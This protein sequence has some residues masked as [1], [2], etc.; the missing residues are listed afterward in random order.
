[1]TRIIPDQSLDWAVGYLLYLVEVNLAVISTLS[2][3]LKRNPMPRWFLILHIQSLTKVTCQIWMAMLHKTF[4]QTLQSLMVRRSQPNVLLM[5]ITPGASSLSDPALASLF[6]SMEIQSFGIP[7]ERQVTI[8]TSSFG[9][10]FVA[11][12]VTAESIWGLRYKLQMLG[13]P[14]ERVQS[15]F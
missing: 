11:A 14:F 15:S 10:E 9:T 12:K 4:P 8:E 5:W 2:H 7:A 3:I 13:V 1:M 6:L